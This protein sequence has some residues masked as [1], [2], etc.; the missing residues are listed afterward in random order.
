MSRGPLA[1]AARFG[2][3]AVRRQRVHHQ[4]G[5]KRLRPPMEHAAELGRRLAHVEPAA[6]VVYSTV[7]TQRVGVKIK[8]IG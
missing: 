2:R 4:R 3:G 5:G 7:S 6:S 1:L 8:F